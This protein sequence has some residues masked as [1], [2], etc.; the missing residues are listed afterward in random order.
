MFS[1]VLPYL[2][3]V[4]DKKKVHIPD[5]PLNNSL[6]W[7]YSCWREL[8]V[9]S[10]LLGSKVWEVSF[11]INSRG[12][13]LLLIWSQFTYLGACVPLVSTSLKHWQI[14]NSKWVFK[15]PNILFCLIRFSLWRQQPPTYSQRVTWRCSLYNWSFV[16]VG[17]LHFNLRF[18]RKITP[19]FCSGSEMLWIIEIF[20]KILLINSLLFD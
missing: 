16:N 3:Y 19:T 14:C 10:H 13:H 7:T 6:K 8:S 17:S 12:L 2:W 5:K 20:T 18:W 1:L 4:D 11:Q 9:P 15:I